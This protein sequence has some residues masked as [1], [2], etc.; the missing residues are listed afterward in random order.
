V[1]LTKFR[2]F[3]ETPESE[4]VPID[5]FS[6][7]SIQYLYRWTKSAL[8]YNKNPDTQEETGIVYFGEKE[9]AEYTL[10]LTE[11]EAGYMGLHDEWES[12]KADFPKREQA[13]SRLGTYLEWQKREHQN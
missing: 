3:G 11:E 12:S 9:G 7:P 1:K 2:G 4:E 8:E 6:E 13:F 10:Y 5:Q